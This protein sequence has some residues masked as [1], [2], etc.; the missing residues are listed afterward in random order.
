MAPVRKH[1]QRGALRDGLNKLA[2]YLPLHRFF[3]KPRGGAHALAPALHSRL[4]ALSPTDSLASASAEGFP[5]S[6]FDK[7]LRHFQGG[8]GSLRAA[9]QAPDTSPAGQEAL[10]AMNIPLLT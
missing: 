4:C 7:V 1:A 8:S 2:K 9:A 5:M 3:A 6:F 10:A